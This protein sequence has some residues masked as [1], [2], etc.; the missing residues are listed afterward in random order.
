[1]T[2]PVQVHISEWQLFQGRGEDVELNSTSV[3]SSLFQW[4]HAIGQKCMKT[5]GQRKVKG[6]SAVKL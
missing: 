4:S 1:M 2:G 3:T 6:I 5:P